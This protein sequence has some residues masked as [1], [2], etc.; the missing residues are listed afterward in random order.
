MFQLVYRFFALFRKGENVSVYQTFL[1]CLPVY[2]ETNKPRNHPLLQWGIITRVLM[3][4]FLLPEREP[5]K[6]TYIHLKKVKESR[7]STTLAPSKVYSR[8]LKFLPE[9]FAGGHWTC[10]RESWSH[11]PSFVPRR[12]ERW[13]AS[14]RGG[15]PAVCP[16]W[17]SPPHPGQWKQQSFTTVCLYAWTSP[18]PGQWTAILHQCHP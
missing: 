14:E 5:L 13:P 1:Q 18:H 4:N 7:L 12:T 6:K 9:Q 8:W 10:R 3:K 15:R 11:R 16:G 2:G 17:T